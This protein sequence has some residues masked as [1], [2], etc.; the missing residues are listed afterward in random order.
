[1]IKVVGKR[2][3]VKKDQIDLGGMV[4]TPTMIEDGL[5]N[6]GKVVA[7]GQIGD[8]YKLLGLKKGVTVFFKKFFIVNHEQDN[9]L[10]FVDV[11]EVVGLEK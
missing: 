9:P 2:I 10:C 6:K 1:M 5:K 4:G 8:K 7:V 11:D 3:L